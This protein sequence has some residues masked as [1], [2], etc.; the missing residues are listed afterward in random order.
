M[1]LLEGMS[2]WFPSKTEIQKWIEDQ[3]KEFAEVEN[4]NP[5]LSLEDWL[6]KYIFID[7]HEIFFGGIHQGLYEWLDRLEYTH[8]EI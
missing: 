5:N 6:E 8:F 4:K 7:I 3:E 1:N 2:R